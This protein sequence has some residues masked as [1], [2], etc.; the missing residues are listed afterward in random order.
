MKYKQ[1]VRILACCVV[2]LTLAAMPVI[3]QDAPANSQ[4]PLGQPGPRGQTPP[5]QPGPRGAAATPAA[6]PSTGFLISA[7]ELNAA[8]IQLGQLAVTKA[9]SERVKAYAQMLVKDHTA[10]LQK[11]Q[12]VQGEASS[13]PPLTTTHV[14]LKARLSG[15][16]GAEFDRAYIEAMVAGH[17]DAAKLFEQ[18]IVASPSRPQSPAKPTDAEV[19]SVA[20]ELLPTIKRHLEQAEQIQNGLK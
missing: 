20:K 1:P 5:P 19:M 12:R 6:N 10:A 7:I 11:L 4:Q 16:S 13:I 18:E 3:G 9:Q 14:E 15:L 17:R 2:S 8:E